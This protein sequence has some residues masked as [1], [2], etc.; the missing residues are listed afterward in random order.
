[1]SI[2]FAIYETPSPIALGHFSGQQLEKLSENIGFAIPLM[3]IPL[4]LEAVH[5]LIVLCFALLSTVN[6]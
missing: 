1:V 5:C 3:L 6:H 4:A 2:Q